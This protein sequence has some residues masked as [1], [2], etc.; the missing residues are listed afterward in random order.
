MYF[1][2]CQVDFTSNFC[3]LASGAAYSLSCLW[4]ASQ[5]KTLGDS[6]VDVTPARALIICLDISARSCM[7]ETDAQEGLEEADQTIERG[8]P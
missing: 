4:Q 6:L 1:T 7:I 8:A 5:Y 2:F 3:W